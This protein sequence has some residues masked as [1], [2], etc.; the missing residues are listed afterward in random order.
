VATECFCGCGAE[1]PFGRRRATNLVGGQTAEQLAVIR[2]ALDGGAEPEHAAQLADLVSRGDALVEALRE[3]VH[4]TRDRK[5]FD[6]GASRA[7][8]KEALDVR[9]RL[10]KDAIAQDYAGWNA[11]EQSELIHTGKRAAAHI[12]D[13]HDTGMTVNE[14]PRVKVRLRVEPPGEEPF[15]VERKVLVSRVRIPRAGERVEV[16]YDPD[17]PERFTFRVG[18]LADDAAAAAA[19]PADATIE[20]LERLARLREQGVLTDQEFAE[21]KRR[22]LGADI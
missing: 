17:D 21:Q 22:V 6:K 15:E 7:W 16:V 18:D 14:N 8:M 3:V 4:G 20:A 1:V 5:D 11:L 9:E 13:V 10:A 12:L 19:T 2:G